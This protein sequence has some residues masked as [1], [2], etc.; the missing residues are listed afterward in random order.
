VGQLALPQISDNNA[1]KRLTFIMKANKARNEAKG[2]QIHSRQKLS[3][4]Q[5]KC[6]LKQF[7]WSASKFCWS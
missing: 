6:Q 7:N 4:D 5:A 2:P 3:R 1:A